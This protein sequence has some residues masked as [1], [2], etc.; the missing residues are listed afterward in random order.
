MRNEEG[1]LAE[2]ATL[3]D[4]LG[5][6]VL[7]VRTYREPA[8]DQRVFFLRVRRVDALMA[9]TALQRKGYTVVSVH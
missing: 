8:G 7:G 6:E 9:S 3:I 5:G 2:A 1:R 4:E